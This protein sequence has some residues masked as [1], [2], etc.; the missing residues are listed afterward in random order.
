[1]SSGVPWEVNHLQAIPNIQTV[2]IVEKDCRREL[3][4][5]KEGPPYPFEASSHPRNA[6][7]RWT[8]LVV[9]CVQPRGRDPRARLFRNPS[10]IQNMIQVAMCDDNPN[11][12]L[13]IPS[14][15]LQSA[16]Q[17]V[18]TS[19]ESPVDEVESVRVTQNIEIHAE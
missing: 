1:M 15:L 4:K 12:A 14:A 18:A 16:P 5:S 6:V 11:D 10:D 8:A 17:L 2:A 13:A 9:R 3:P 7:I 19:N